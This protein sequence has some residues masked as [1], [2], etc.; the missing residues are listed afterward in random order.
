MLQ[1]AQLLTSRVSALV[2]FVALEDILPIFSASISM[3]NSLSS[4]AG[5]SA[6]GL[7]GCTG[8]NRMKSVGFC[9]GEGGE[10]D[11]ILTS[12]DR[13]FGDITG[14]AAGDTMGETSLC[15]VVRLLEVE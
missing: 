10:G 13:K 14:D 5:G 12:S 4:A 8:S 2:R 1:S 6:I 3:S 9:A 11:A 15:M 7:I